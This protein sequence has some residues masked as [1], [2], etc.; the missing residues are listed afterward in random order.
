MA[1]ARNGTAKL[2]ILSLPCGEKERQNQSR[3]KY[4]E[5]IAENLK[6]AGCSLGWVSTVDSEGRTIWIVDAQRDGKRFIVRADEKLTA[7]V[8]L[9]RAIQELA[10]SLI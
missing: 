3:M 10:V 4:W 9:Q 6:K 5:T 7:F 1:K 2:G 8:Q